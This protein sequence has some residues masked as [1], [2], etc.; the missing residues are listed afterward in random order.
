MMRLGAAVAAVTT[1][2]A[3]FSS[4]VEDLSSAVPEIAGQ[5]SSHAGLSST[6][7]KQD[8]GV[9]VATYNTALNR[10][11][12]GQL[13]ADMAAGTDEQARNIAAVIQAANPDILILNEFDYDPTGQALAD[14]QA[15]Y[16][17]QPQHGQQP[18]AYPYTFSAQVNTGVDSGLDLDGNGVLGEGNDAYGFGLFPGQYGMAVLSK[19]PIDTEKVRTLQQLRWHSMPNNRLPYDYYGDN[20]HQLRLSSKSHWDVPVTVAGESIH[21]I[22]A[23][24]TP[25]AFEGPE[26]RNT[27]RN[28]DEIRL[29][30]DYV[31][32][33]ER[34]E[35]I[36][37][38]AGVRGGLADGARFVVFGDM[39]SDPHDGDNS[40]ATGI[41]Q[42]L[43]LPALQDPQPTSVGA[44]QSNE[45]GPGVHRTPAKTDTA[46]FSE[47]KPGNLRVDYV[48]PSAGFTV[49]DSGVFWPAKGEPL[50]E[51][52]TPERT[53]DHHLVWAT[54]R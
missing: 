9:T 21:L 36:V 4:A 40:G 8:T 33:G 18:V 47:P 39:N 2:L 53:S 32:G 44:E 13:A 38:D 15:N 35:W 3:P 52:M 29:L 22:V 31:S 45:Q 19:Y 34:A 43:T 48:L 26:Q 54:I 11:K 28:G 23:H 50:A 7:Q 6:A 14:F 16:L 37:D 49:T 51:L 24:P 20:A 27:R 17:G 46:D 12:A 5:L 1:I 25:P 42:L 30:A 10:P 41:D